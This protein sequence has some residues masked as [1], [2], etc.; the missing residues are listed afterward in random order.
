MNEY[1]SQLSSTENVSTQDQLVIYENTIDGCEGFS[2][3]VI[4]HLAA[5]LMLVGCQKNDK[6]SSSVRSI[7]AEREAL[8]VD[9]DYPESFGY[10]CLW[11]AFRT[12]NPEA[13]VEALR[14][15]D[16]RMCA[17]KQGIDSAYH[18]KMF[19]TPA[20]RGWVLAA[21]VSLPDIRSSKSDDSVSVMLM[22]LGK[23]FPDVQCYGTHR[24]VEYHGWA[25]VI[26]GK[27]VRQYAYLGER[28]KPFAMTVR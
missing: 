19:V 3:I 12:E 28:G 14:L 25:R 22:E 20:I 23:R 11:L 15:G 17:W 10:K 13:V 27:I 18:G 21:S 2:R 5:M 4:L 26:S 9:T 8:A 6:P 7:D 24:V 1:C 16:V